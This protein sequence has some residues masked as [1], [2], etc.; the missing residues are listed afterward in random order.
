MNFKNY[1]KNNQKLKSFILKILLVTNQARPRWWVK[2]FLN[3]FFNNISR[4]SIIRRK[5]RLDIVPFVPF[6][7]GNKTMIEEYACLNNGL[8]EIIIGE[9]SSIGIGNTIIGPVH[10]GNNVIIAQHVTI[11][12]LNHSYDNINIAIRDQQCTTTL[13][14]IEDECWIG[15]NAVIVAGV[16]VGFHSII[17]AGSVVTKSIPPYTLVG[18][19]PAKIIKKYDFEMNEWTRI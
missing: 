12:G 3:P 13:I 14:K 17:A 5:A 19:N 7:V 15:S 16:T 6:T 18:G 10:I 8:G 11:S 1:I 2:V 9:N 4:G